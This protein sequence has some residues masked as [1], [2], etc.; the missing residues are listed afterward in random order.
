MRGVKM[1]G[2]RVPLERVRGVHERV[3]DNR[4]AR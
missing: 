2:R 3:T 4:E 1:T